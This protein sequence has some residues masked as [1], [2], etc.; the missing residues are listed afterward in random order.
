MHFYA[1]DSSLTNSNTR[2]LHT[3]NFLE[4][5]IFTNWTLSLKQL[6]SR[7]R[8]QLIISITVDKCDVLA[9]GTIREFAGVKVAGKKLKQG[10]KF[11]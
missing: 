7:E 10:C 3:I 8:T 9:L 5:Y 6:A 11:V 2:I 4:N 1:Y